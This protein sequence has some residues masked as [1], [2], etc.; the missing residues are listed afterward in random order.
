MQ[1]VNNYDL[2]LFD[3]D[4][5][6]VNT[7]WI[8]Y[9]AYKNMCAERGFDLDWDFNRYIEVAHYRAEGLE[10]QIYAK[11]PQLHA[12][13][14]NW[15]VLYEEKRQAL[16]H[17]YTTKPIPLMEGV[18]DLLVKLQSLNKKRCV[19]THSDRGVVKMIREK[20][21]ILDTI[22]NWIVREDYSTPKPS[23]ECYNKAINSL[24]SNGDRVIGF[25]DTPRGLNALMGSSAKPVM[26]TQMEYPEMADIRSRGVPIFSSFVEIS[27]D[28]RYN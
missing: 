16:L 21:P 25:E 10:E 15:K 12:D 17:L 28:L 6:L 5:L 13:E 11:F 4:G 2:F 9:Q 8:H 7:E 22:P 19:V 26:V 23:P 20:N 1:W 27:E 24:A 18:E 14:P 3:F